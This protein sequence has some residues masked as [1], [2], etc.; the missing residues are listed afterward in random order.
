M[1]DRPIHLPSSG[2]YGQEP[3]VTAEVVITQSTLDGIV[4]LLTWLEGY[5]AAKSG[6]IPGDFELVMFYRE[7]RRAIQD[8]KK[9]TP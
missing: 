6:Q 5:Q 1:T 7:L 9:A 3:S 4:Q 2:I 8:P